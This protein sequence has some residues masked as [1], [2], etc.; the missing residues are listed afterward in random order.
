MARIPY[1][2]LS[3]PTD[4]RKHVDPESPPGLRLAAAKGA[5]PTTTDAQLGIC[6]LLSN[7]PD[8]RVR[9]AARTTL[10]EM[11]AAQVV[12]AIGQNTHSKVLELLAVLRGEDQEIASRISTIR[13]AND[14]T[15]VRLAEKA[16]PDLCERLVYNQERL[17]MTP[18]VFVALY[19][20]PN[21][22]D[23]WIEKASSFLRMQRQLPEVPPERPFRAPEQD[24]DS[25]APSQAAAEQPGGIDEMDLEAELE[26]EI[27]AALSGEQSPTLQKRTEQALEMFDLDDVHQDDDLLSGFDFDFKDDMSS[28]S[29]DL[30]EERDKEPEPDE[31]QSLEQEVADLSVGQKIKLAYLGNKEVRNVLIRDRNKLV[32]VAVVRSGRC[33]DGEIAAIAGNRNIHD[34]V[35]R[36]ISNNPEWLRKYPVRVSLVNNP[37]TPVSVAVSLVKGLNRRDLQELA[38]NHNVSSVV[39]QLAKRMF[40]QKYKS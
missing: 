8:P 14:R 10:L 34:D 11:P 31:K 3:I 1:E 32:S 27:E 33:T 29:W 30:T 5:V 18:Q 9:E 15:V 37:K 22:K 2:R 25:E 23:H 13:N 26:A 19:G 4:L 6:Y 28:F 36:E 24:T 16:E 40:K 12:S 35:L 17:L 38:R 20:N 39:N 21:C 7:D